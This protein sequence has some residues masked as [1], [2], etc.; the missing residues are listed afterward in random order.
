M[1][2]NKIIQKMKTIPIVSFVFAV[3][4]GSYIAL[5][6][7]L[8]FVMRN[9]PE[10]YPRRYPYIW[11]MIIALSIYLILV[12]IAWIKQLWCEEKKMAC[13]IRV[14]AW[15]AIWMAVIY[16]L[17]YGYLYLVTLSFLNITLTVALLGIGIF[18]LFAVSCVMVP[19]RLMF[20]NNIH[21]IYIISILVLGMILA[22]S[23]PVLIMLSIF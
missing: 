12:L 17:G 10:R 5:Y 2:K 9:G 15:T 21:K 6:P 18:L 8:E 20:K 1:V 23:V 16:V 4:I 7:M 3:G 22:I 14:I 13:T 19:Y 11:T